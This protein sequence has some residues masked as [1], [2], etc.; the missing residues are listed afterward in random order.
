M[1]TKTVEAKLPE[2]PKRVDRKLYGGF[3]IC[4]VG[5]GLMGLAGATKFIPLAV[6]GAL[7]FLGGLALT[8]SSDT[9]KA[10]R[11]G[12]RVEGYA[13]WQ[14]AARRFDLNGVNPS[15]GLPMMGG[16]DTAGNAFGTGRRND[17]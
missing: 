8:L 7:V 17:Y 4:L 15:T 2:G 9:E 3:A 12:P 1:D 13:D 14:L 16:F 11:A 10:K 6:V 5:F